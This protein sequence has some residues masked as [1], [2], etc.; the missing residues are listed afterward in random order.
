[1]TSFVNDPLFDLSSTGQYLIYIYLYA[2]FLCSRAHSA[3]RARD[4]RVSCIQNIYVQNIYVP[5][6][7]WEN[8]RCEY[9]VHIL[10]VSIH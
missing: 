7:S 5:R 10:C 1:M 6:L 9:Y 4:D 8:A 3:K 2:R